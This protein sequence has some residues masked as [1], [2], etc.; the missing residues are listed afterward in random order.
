MKS[1]TGY[2]LCG[3]ESRRMT[4]PKALLRWNNNVF[5]ADHIAQQLSLGGCEQ[6]FLVGKDMFLYHCQTRT[7]FENATK[8]HPLCGILCALEHSTTKLICVAPCDMP[9][10][11]SNMISKLL[12]QEPIAYHHQNPL[13]SLL[14]KDH[15]DRV[16]HF[17]SQDNSVYD[18]V[19]IGNELHESQNIANYNSPKEFMMDKDNPQI[20]FEQASSNS[21]KVHLISLEA[22]IVEES[23]P[24]IPS[25]LEGIPPV[26]QILESAGRSRYL[27]F[28]DGQ[29]SIYGYPDLLRDSAKVLA[30]RHV[31]GLPEIVALHRF[32]SFV[33]FG[34]KENSPL[35]LQKYRQAMKDTYQKY[36]DHLSTLNFSEDHVVGIEGSN[37][38][39][40]RNHEIFRY[41]QGNAHTLGTVETL[42][43]VQQALST[44]LLQW[45]Q[46]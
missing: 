15:I 24:K 2:V 33:A 1:V 32:P 34:I 21:W 41:K 4:Y 26:K 29:F 20:T 7:I 25:A 44:L 40:S 14:S 38:L 13:L 43:S 8:Q 12:Q 22:N 16:R 11:N 30:I 36:K 42:G 31:G 27:S 35:K 45:S 18:F 17:L 5:F 37:L 9:Q 46:Q 39:F 28:E 19:S 3:G 23:W 6:V 10:I